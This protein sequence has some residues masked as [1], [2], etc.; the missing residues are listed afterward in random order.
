MKRT[1]AV[2]IVV[3]AFCTT[4]VADDATKPSKSTVEAVSLSVLKKLDD[5][6]FP[7]SAS[8]TAVDV[9]VSNQDRRLSGRRSFERDHRVQR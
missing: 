6:N 4:L 9:L 7:Y 3:V 1:L 5:K 8:S 2:L